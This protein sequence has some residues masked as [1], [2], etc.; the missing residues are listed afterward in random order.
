MEKNWRG[1]I[2]KSDVVKATGGPVLRLKSGRKEI[3]T[4]NLQKVYRTLQNSHL[5]SRI[6]TFSDIEGLKNT[7]SM[8]LSYCRICSTETGKQNFLKS[9]RGNPGNKSSDTS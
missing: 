1:N 5:Q 3:A 9:K 7:Y 4:K 6:K 8:C 2:K